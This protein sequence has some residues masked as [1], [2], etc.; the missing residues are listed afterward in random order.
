MPQGRRIPRPP[1]PAPRRPDAPEDGDATDPLVAKAAGE[2]IVGWAK[3]RSC[4]DC[5]RACA[6]R[7]YGTGHPRAPIMLVKERPAREDL[8]STN[9]F[10]SDAE[11]LTKAF[12]ALG[13]PASWLFGSTAVRCGDA[14]ANREEVRAC[15]QHLLLE[16][17]A[18]APRVIVAFGEL[19]TQAVVALDGRCGLKIPPQ[20]ARGEAI[21]IRSSL[22]LVV[23]EALPGGLTNKEAKRRLWRDLRLLPDLLQTP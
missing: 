15:A 12:D 6:D 1:S 21:R 10:A 19:A 18:V 3:I 14:A 16:I 7:A 8:E 17:E 2:L 5:E 9:A 13:I 11:A 23:T 22:T 4:E 20:V